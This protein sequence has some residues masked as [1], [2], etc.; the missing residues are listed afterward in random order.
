MKFRYALALCFSI[1]L[2]VVWVIGAY[3][4]ADLNWLATSLAWSVSDRGEVVFGVLFFSAV[5][6]F[7]A[8]GM[9]AP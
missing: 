5:P 9:G 7:I 6:I 8:L 1:Y 3:L 2:A 4:N